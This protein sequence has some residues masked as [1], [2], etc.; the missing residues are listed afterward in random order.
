MQSFDTDFYQYYQSKFIW[1]KL[2]HYS[3]PPPPLPRSVTPD[4]R[5]IIATNKLVKLH[6]YHWSKQMNF[7]Q[8]SRYR[9]HFHVRRS[10]L[11]LGNAKKGLLVRLRR[12][13]TAV[14]SAHYAPIVCQ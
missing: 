6:T 2:L 8:A 11:S 4:K 1:S 14:T 12:Q 7:R 3:P 9:C 13:G 5:L 10:A